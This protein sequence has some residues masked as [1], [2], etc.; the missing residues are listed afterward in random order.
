MTCLTNHLPFSSVSS[1][2]FIFFHQII[3][4]VSLVIYIYVIYFLNCFFFAFYSLL[5][6]LLFFFS[7]LAPFIFFF[8]LCCTFRLLSIYIRRCLFKTVLS[9]ERFSQYCCFIHL[10]RFRIKIAFRNTRCSA[11]YLPGNS[12]CY[13]LIPSTDFP[14]SVTSAST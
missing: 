7:F 6:F 9:R 4:C 3:S 1:V 11:S 2:Y 5:N 10:W 14:Q 13:L 12:A 8:Y